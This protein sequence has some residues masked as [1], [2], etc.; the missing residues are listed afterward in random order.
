[1]TKPAEPA[2]TI[3]I[4][5]AG[6]HPILFV[7]GETSEPAT[8]LAEAMGRA[9][10]KLRGKRCSDTETIWRRAGI[11]RGKYREEVPVVTAYTEAAILEGGDTDVALRRRPVQ[12]DPPRTVGCRERE[13]QTPEPRG[14][15][16]EP[17]VSDPDDPGTAPRTRGW[18]WDAYAQSGASEIPS[19]RAG[20]NR[21]RRT[22]E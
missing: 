19:A 9:L 3:L 18:A 12:G 13:E 7:G 2:T 6:H 20:I 5:L 1:M 11:G 4:A 10:P 21:G 8:A 22:R 17:R 15:T 14:C 16:R